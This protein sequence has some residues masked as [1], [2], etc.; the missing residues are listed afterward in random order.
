MEMVAFA[1]SW[2][3]A[4]YLELG[5]IRAA[6]A[7]LEALTRVDA[8]IRQRTYSIAMLLHHIMLALMRGELAEAERL[9]MQSMSAAA[10]RSY[11][12]RR[13]IERP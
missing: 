5:D 12:P 7:D 3:L 6:E 2:R 9:I 1:H 8:R 13:S 11:R 4:S 10:R